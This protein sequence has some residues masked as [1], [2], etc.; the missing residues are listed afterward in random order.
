MR[1]SVLYGR[2]SSVMMNSIASDIKCIPIYFCMSHRFEQIKNVMF[3][4]FET[5]DILGEH[6]FLKWKVFGNVSDILL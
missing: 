1:L 2:F 3:K 4:I 6:L 5:I